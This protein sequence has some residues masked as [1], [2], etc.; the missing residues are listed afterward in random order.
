MLTANVSTESLFD[1]A[2]RCGVLRR[3]S[4]TRLVFPFP[5]IQEY[6]AGQELL[7]KH[8]HEISDRAARAVER[9]WAQAVQFALEKLADGSKIAQAMLDVPDDAFATGVRLLA[10]CILNG[11]VCS[12]EMRESVGVRLAH[13]WHRQSYW[14]A[15]RTGQLLND[16]W[17][18]TCGTGRA[19][20]LAQ[21][22]PVARWRR[23][24]PN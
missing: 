23:G 4:S 19:R 24:N 9:P 16:G 20:S 5:I 1:D 7:E 3:S 12:T 11:M 2:L 10:R 6:L 18:A 8:Q 15:K 17:S 22:G 21:A 13:V 14:T